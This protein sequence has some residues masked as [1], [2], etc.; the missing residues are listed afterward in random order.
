MEGIDK[1]DR[2]EIKRVFIETLD[3]IHKELGG[4]ECDVYDTECLTIN[5]SPH[6]GVI[7][8]AL[9]FLFASTTSTYSFP[10]INDLRRNHEQAK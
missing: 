3:F 2:N 10:I 9:L 1:N 5:Q 4:D 7:G 6:L 8:M